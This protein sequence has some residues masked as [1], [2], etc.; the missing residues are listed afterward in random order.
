[1]I[2]VIIDDGTGVQYHY[3]MQAS[4]EQQIREFGE[5][6]WSEIMMVEEAPEIRRNYPMRLTIKRVK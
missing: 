6:Q 4:A 3:T 2:Q 1:V 5:G